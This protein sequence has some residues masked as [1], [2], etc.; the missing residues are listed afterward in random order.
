MCCWP[1]SACLCQSLALFG[2]AQTAF[3]GLMVRMKGGNQPAPDPAPPA[4]P[5]DAAANVAILL[6]K[7]GPNLKDIVAAA[8]QDHLKK[9]AVTDPNA[10]P[11]A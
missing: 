9:A 3:G 2:L 7:L 1:S 6:E 4:A 10:Q 5:F 8:V 11:K